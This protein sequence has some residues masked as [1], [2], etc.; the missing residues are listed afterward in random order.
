VGNKTAEAVSVVYQSTEVLRANPSNARTHSKHQIRQIAHSIDTFGFLSPIL[1]DADNLIVAGHGRLAAA[2]LLGLASVPTVPV[3]HLSSDQLRA[4]LI[5][6]N[7]IAQNAGWDEEILAIEF[8]HLLSMDANFD[9]TVSGFEMSEVDLIIEN[10]KGKPDVADSFEPPKQFAVSNAGDLWF[11]EKNRILC[12]NA[13]E[14]SSYQT[15]MEGKKAHLAFSDP[16]Y[17]VRIDGNVSGK[18]K[19]R[20]GDFVMG[21]GEMDSGEFREFLAAAFQRATEYSVSGSIHYICMDWRHVEEVLSAGNKVFDSL[22]NMCVWVK[23]RGSQGSFYRS[24]HELVFVFRNGKTRHQNNVQLGKYGRYRTNVWRYPSIATLSRQSEEGSLLAMHPTV[25]PLALVS[26]AILDSSLRGNVVLDSFLGSGTTLMA[27][28][29]V[30]RVCYGIELDPIYVDVAIRRWQRETG[31]HAIHSKSGRS[32][33]ELSS[34]A[35]GRDD[36][37]R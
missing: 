14:V 13:L 27:A 6:D 16:P 23:D 17:N 34:I 12:G 32:F 22:L 37:V 30:G 20:H 19:V 21:V 35:E 24:A 5:A 11:L 26:D 8:Q 28:E 1:T 9:V 25:K 18:G 29:R 36:R 3:K 31:G 15:L 7:R 10:A 33:D 2:R 4:F